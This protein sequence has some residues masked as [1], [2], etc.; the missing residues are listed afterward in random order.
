MN[1]MAIFSVNKKNGD[2]PQASTVL[3]EEDIGIIINHVRVT[4]NY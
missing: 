3:G 2:T 1:L 4:W